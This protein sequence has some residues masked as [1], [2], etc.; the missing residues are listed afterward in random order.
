M[1]EG[2]NGKVK[3]LST[4]DRTTA[5]SIMGSN[6]VPQPDKPSGSTD[7]MPWE[8]VYDDYNQRSIGM[9]ARELTPGKYGSVDY[10][11]FRASKNGSG[12]VIFWTDQMD[13]YY[14]PTESERTLATRDLGQMFRGADGKQ[15]TLNLPVEYYNKSV[16]L[17]PGNL[18]SGLS[19]YLTSIET[20]QVKQDTAALEK[21]NA[22]VD[23]DNEARLSA[24]RIRN[25]NADRQRGYRQ[26]RA[27]SASPTILTGN[28]LGGPNSILGGRSLL[29]M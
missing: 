21:R 28:A 20:E 12:D 19:D 27:R 9:R 14:S 10:G 11:N 4:P 18:P 1:G 8:W 25:A 26:V 29:G 5:S 23:A 24:N 22:Q 16:V 6:G 2:S 3:P 17:Q 7:S 13:H 15:Y